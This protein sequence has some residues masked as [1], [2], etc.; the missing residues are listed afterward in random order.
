M[1]AGLLAHTVVGFDLCTRTEAPKKSFALVTIPRT[2]SR[3]VTLGLPK[4]NLPAQRPILTH[5]LVTPRS[6]RLTKKACRLVTI[7]NR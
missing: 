1:V 2:K 5:D 3:A 7:P 4:Q 6:S